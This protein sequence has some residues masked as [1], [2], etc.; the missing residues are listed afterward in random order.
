MGGV[1][2]KKLITHLRLCCLMLP[3]GSMSIN[4]LTFALF[5][6]ANLP[7]VKTTLY[8]VIDRIDFYTRSSC[9]TTRY[10]SNSMSM[11]AANKWR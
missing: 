5:A 7:L 9:N 2:F 3:Y 10:C 1:E 8:K 11:I 6:F 4:S